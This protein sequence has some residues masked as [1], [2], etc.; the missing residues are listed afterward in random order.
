[1]EDFLKIISHVRR[2]KTATKELTIEELSEV[3]AKIEKIIEARTA[4]EA[5]EKQRN[6]EKE[7]K[8]E[9]YREMLAADGIAPGELVA[10]LPAKK[11]NEHL[12][13]QST[14]LQMNLVTRL[15]GR[16]RAVCLTFSK[17]ESKLVSR[18]IR[19]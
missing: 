12:A 13:L 11:E 16:D 18:L 3:K 1:M 4:E 5:K 6:A 2:F 15:P 10:E 9:K 8:I 19:F 17:R 7:Q 14:K